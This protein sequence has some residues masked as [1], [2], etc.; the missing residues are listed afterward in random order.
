MPKLTTGRT[1]LYKLTHRD[2]DRI[3]LHRASINA[4]Q[5]EELLC[6]NTPHE[7]D[8]VP[9]IVVQVWTPETFNG[10]AF[11]D[12]NQTVW[13]TTIPQDQDDKRP[14]TWHWPEHSAHENHE[15]TRK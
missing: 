15:E 2:C 3:M 11:L 6:G 12:G 7:G 8:I 4:H 5:P 1:V 13:L 9:A 10:Q 14:G